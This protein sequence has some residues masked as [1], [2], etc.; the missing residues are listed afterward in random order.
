M[1]VPA[2]KS[3][4]EKAIK[5]NYQ[6]LLKELTSITAQEAISMQLEGHAKDTLMNVHDLVAYLVGWGALV[7][8][9]NRLK[10][11]GE[12]VDFPETGYKWNELGKLAQKFYADYAEDD[13]LHLLKK[14]DET[15]TDILSLIANK[16][17]S[18]Y[19]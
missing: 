15:V 4:L 10:D 17:Y 14:L 11:N 2:N 9:W 13:Y 16:T 5:Q 12:Q 7:L 8:K 6:S 1:G 18:I 3:E 19:P